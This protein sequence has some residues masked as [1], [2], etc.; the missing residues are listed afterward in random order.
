M[1]LAASLLIGVGS[2]AAQILVPYAAHL[3]P[4]VT[5][6]KNVGSVMSGVE[7]FIMRSCLLPSAYFGLRS[8]CCWSVRHQTGVA[9]FA[10]VGV[11]GAAVTPVAGRLADKGWIRPATG[12]ALGLAVVS[13]LLPLVVHGGSL[14]SMISLVV[15]AIV[16]DMAVSANLVLGQRAI[17]ALGAELRSR[18]NG[19]FMAIF[20]AGGAIG[21]A[22]GGWAYA[23]G[24]WEAALWLGVLFPVLALLYFFTEKREAR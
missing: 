14:L 17:F 24:G 10:L 15:A 20:F 7:L 22:V 3:S 2:V 19:L 12:I 13:L 4:E 5:K 1:F 6:G 11:S 18:L 8:P 21:S 9:L 23:Q 16:L